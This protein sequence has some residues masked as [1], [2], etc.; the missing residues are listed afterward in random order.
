MTLLARLCAVNSLADSV[1]PGPR[2]PHLLVIAG[3]A[4]VMSACPS[5]HAEP[6]PLPPAQQV[7]VNQA[8]LQGMIFLKNS[9]GIDGSWA[10]TDKPHRLGYA[11]LPALTLLECGMPANHSVIQKA[12]AFINERSAKEENTY[13]LALAIMFLDRL[14]SNNDDFLQALTQKKA[15]DQMIQVLALRLIAGQTATGGWKYACPNRTVAQHNQLKKAL[16][17]ERLD[18]SRLVPWLKKL[19]VF[20]DPDKLMAREVP[21]A[22]KTKK[23]QVQPEPPAAEDEAD[24]SNTHFAALALWVA[25]RH[26]VR[27]QRSFK[28]IGKRFRTSQNPDGGWGY[29]YQLGGG[30][31]TTATMTCTGLVGLA[32]ERGFTPA[33]EAAGAAPTTN[34]AAIVAGL[35]ANPSPLNGVH[36]ART[37]EQAVARAAEKKKRTDEP[38]T[39][40][41]FQA[42]ANHVGQPAGRIENIPLGDLYFMWALERVAMIYDL[43]TIGD[44]DWYRWGAEMLLANIKPDGYWDVKTF[45]D[46]ANE[47]INSSFAL[48]FLR[49]ANLADDLTTKLRADPS[50]LDKPLARKDP[51]A[52]TKAQTPPPAPPAAP[53]PEN[54]TPAGKSTVA[55]LSTSKTS[56]APTTP[57][58]ARPTPPPEPTAELRPAAA[59]PKESNKLILWGGAAVAVVLIGVALALVV[60]GMQQKTT[61]DPDRDPRRSGA[62]RKAEAGNRRNGASRKSSPKR[63][64]ET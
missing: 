35:A 46:A 31:P 27:V 24:N 38:V 22:R 15:I 64:E 44:K 54:K 62:K 32:L 6:L 20:Q 56:T 60:M 25:Q 16:E 59:T 17:D 1:A 45:G 49:Q 53:P 39:L 2:H 36:A 42:L 58:K 29:K 30:K 5:A 40:K 51:P 9:Q 18:R 23:K 48:L 55:S 21:D 4:V 28:L 12:A 14:G 50:V 3:L 61:S 26:G 33:A 8:M 11:A 47:V 52:E 19:P 7:K 63:K 34:A 10:A 43:Q 37:A 13:D 41:G 57:E